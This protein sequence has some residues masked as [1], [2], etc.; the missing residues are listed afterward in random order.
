MLDDLEVELVE[1]Y[2]RRQGVLESSSHRADPHRTALSRRQ[3]HRDRPVWRMLARAAAASGCA[4]SS[5]LSGHRPSDR[6]PFCAVGF[7]VLTYFVQ[8]LRHIPP[9]SRARAEMARVVSPGGG[10][11]AEFP[12][13]ASSAPAGQGVIR[14]PQVGPSTTSHCSTSP[15]DDAA[16]S[17]LPPTEAR[18]CAFA[19]PRLRRDRVIA[20]ESP[21][22]AGGSRCGARG[23]ALGRASVHA[24][25]PADLPGARSHFDARLL[26]S[27][28]AGRRLS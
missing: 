19:T 16:A 22:G 23:A 20:P 27:G 1:R 12:T 18:L 25:G 13:R 2:G 3:R 17:A 8:V 24:A 9:T 10:S 7:T 26:V 28:S 4:S 6:A 11:L 5:W 15:H 21:R 14:R